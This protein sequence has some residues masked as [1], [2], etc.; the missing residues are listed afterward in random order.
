M[1]D[2]VTNPIVSDFEIVFNDSFLP[3][4]SASKGF[5]SHSLASLTDLLGSAL[6]TVSSL[7]K[8]AQRVETQQGKE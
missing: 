2:H 4:L 5:D 7:Q 1:T 3:L 8:N 6:N